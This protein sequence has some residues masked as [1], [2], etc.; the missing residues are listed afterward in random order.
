MNRFRPGPDT[1]RAFRDALGQFATGV[2]VVTA[3]GP[4]GPCAITANSFSSVSLDPP[5]V[6]WSI[7][8]G[9][10]RCAVFRSSRRSAIHILAT[11]QE[12]LASRFAKAGDAFDG[13]DWTPDACGVPHLPGCLARFACT[14]EADYPGGDHRILL[15]RVETVDLAPG[16]PM[17]F[18]TGRFGRFV[19]AGD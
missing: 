9:S 17:V 3:A 8:A 16:V 6:L 13:L 11:G 12:A 2:T 14:L 18:A 19:T 7:D 4:D 5:L 15:L 10:R 1:E